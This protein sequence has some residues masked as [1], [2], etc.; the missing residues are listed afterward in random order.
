M[1]A[2]IPGY[3]PDGTSITA[4][5][6]RIMSAT[7]LAAPTHSSPARVAGTAYQ[8]SD[9]LGGRVYLSCQVA[10]ALTIIAGG[11]AYIVLE[12]ASD[13]AFTQNVE[14]WGRTGISGSSGLVSAPANSG[15]LMAE[16]PPNY[17]YRFR[18]VTSSGTP[19][20]TIF[21]VK[22]VLC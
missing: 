7:P 8:I 18:Q 6:Q 15:Q 20:F 21:A 17:Y 16:V 10:L 19:T 13:G 3:T 5:G 22:E 14:E 4:T 9:L 11:A 1:P 2:T 12:T